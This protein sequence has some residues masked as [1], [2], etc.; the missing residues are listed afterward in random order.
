MVD[1]VC[2]LNHMR[3]Q[4]QWAGSMA[5]QVGIDGFIR[6]VPPD[7]AAELLE[8]KE[9]WAMPTGEVPPAPPALLNPVM[10][11]AIAPAPPAAAVFVR[12]MALLAKSPPNVLEGLA[13]S[14]DLELEDAAAEGPRA[15]ADA[16]DA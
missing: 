4:V 10:T 2:K 5:F 15:I 11:A 12:T 9:A 1:L 6:Q 3:G 14:F 8:N 16:L 7:V 13:R